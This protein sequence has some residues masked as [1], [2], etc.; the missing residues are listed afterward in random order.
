MLALN[1]LSEADPLQLNTRLK[2]PKWD[3]TCSADGVP[4]VLP[5]D[6]VRCA[7]G[8]REQAARPA[9]ALRC[10]WLPCC[11]ARSCTHAAPTCPPR[12]RRNAA[13]V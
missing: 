10:L 3:A 4:A 7:S 11:C 13:A 2:L 6:T 8:G 12:F 9:A 5:A 1:N